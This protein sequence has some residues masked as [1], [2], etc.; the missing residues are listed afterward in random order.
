MDECLG[1][2]AGEGG[3]VGGGACQYLVNIAD[4]NVDKR[5]VRQELRAQEYSGQYFEA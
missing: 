2:W 4:A 5:F 1:T 3:S